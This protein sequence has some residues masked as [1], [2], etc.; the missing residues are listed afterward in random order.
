MKWNN[1]KHEEALRKR[2]QKD[3]ERK[4]PYQPPISTGH[5][6]LFESPDYTGAPRDRDGTY[7]ANRR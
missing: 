7:T 1:Q 2:K 6:I 5:T 4:H 3:L